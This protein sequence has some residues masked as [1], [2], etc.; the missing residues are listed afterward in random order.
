MAIEDNS[1][2]RGGHWSFPR[3]LRWLAG[4]AGRVLLALSLI[5]AVTFLSFRVLPVNE[6]TAGFLYLVAILLIAAVGGIIESTLGFFAAMLL[7]NFFF[8]PPIGTLTIS[9]PRNWVT[10]FAFLAT[11]LTAS[12]LS[13]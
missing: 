5:A 11:S 10:L 13:A 3:S 4:L 1:A 8:L 6:L 12:Q 7:F 9:D 2:A